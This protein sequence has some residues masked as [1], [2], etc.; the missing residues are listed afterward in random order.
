MRAPHVKRPEGATRRSLL[1]RAHVLLALQLALLASA[2]CGGDKGPRPLV[3]GEDSCDFCKMAISDPR[4]GAEVRTTTGRLITFDAIECV[5]GYVGAATDPA[6]IA[7]IWVA[8][9]HGGD[10]VPVDSALFVS[11]GSLHSP[12]G[13]QLT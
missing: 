6:R 12:M 3:V 2:A 7:A 4:F 5:A 10:M 13:R 1:R 11:G 9:Y 8:D